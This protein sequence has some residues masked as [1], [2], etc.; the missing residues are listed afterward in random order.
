MR[1][2]HGKVRPGALPSATGTRQGVAMSATQLQLSAV[3]TL[4]L[5]QGWWFA[6]EPGGGWRHQFIVNAVA[7]TSGIQKCPEEDWVFCVH[8]LRTVVKFAISHAHCDRDLASFTAQSFGWSSSA[9]TRAVARPR[10]REKPTARTAGTQL[11]RRQ[12]WVWTVQCSQ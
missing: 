10:L 1:L 2:G 3:E 4:V 8:V 12:P 9:T 5:Q 7:G 6:L 11:R